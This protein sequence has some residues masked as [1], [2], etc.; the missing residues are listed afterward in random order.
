MH[1]PTRRIRF[2]P[3]DLDLTS[4]ELRKGPTR[5]KVPHQSIEILKALLERPGELVTREELRQ[6][7]WPADT[8]VDFEHG[9]NAATRRLREAL[10]DS[11][12]SPKFV[13][14]LPRRGYRFIG[15]SEQ[16]GTPEPG[17]DVRTVAPAPPQAVEPEPV[18]KRIGRRTR[19]WL[20]P[21][22]ALGAVVIAA[23]LSAAL[24]IRFRQPAE[25]SQP[26]VTRLTAYQGTEWAPTL[27]PDGSMV[28]FSWTG[29]TLS[30]HDI[31]VKV[32]G[33]GE[34]IPLT[35]HPA[36]DDSPAWSPDGQRIAFLRWTAQTDRNVDVM[37]M[38]AL[39]RAAEQLIASVPIRP[40]ASPLKRLAWSPD[41]HWLAIAGEVLP[42]EPHGIWLL[43]IDGRQPRRLTTSPASDLGDVSPAFS[44]D[45]RHLAFIR[46]GSTGTSAIHVL[47]LS[48]ELEP[49][50]DPVQVTD[51]SPQILGVA[52]SPQDRAILFSAGSSFGQ[53][54]L[55]RIR[56]TPDRSRAASPVEVL[57]FGEQATTLS[58]SHA[59]RL[60]YAAQFRDSGLWRANI[61]SG[62]PL[63]ASRELPGSTYD[64]HTPSYSPDG[65]RI[66]FVSTR[67]GTEELWI[68]NVDGTDPRQVTFIGGAQCANPQWSPLG[69]DVILFNSRQH[70]P[71][72]LYL[73]HL[74]T[75]TQ[76]RL[77][78]DAFEDIEARWSR[79]GKWIYF[80]ST[81]TGRLEIWKMPAGGGE[82][83]QVTRNGGATAV[84]GRDGFLYFAKSPRSPTALWRMPI[85]GGD[86]TLVLDGLSYSINFAVG[87]RGIYF[88]SR[89]GENTETAAEYF[90]VA[91]NTRTRL[92]MIGKRWWF[93][94]ALSPDEQ[95]FMYSVVNDMNSNLMLV[96]N[97]Y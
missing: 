34:P 92:A 73:L 48:A 13:E 93:G 46:T 65:H 23:A 97:A 18:S 85:A 89:N 32:V 9:V 1:T 77:T 37:L 7:L 51:A 67:T 57:P 2:G 82:A 35:T 88:I 69:D 62:Q 94:V 40:T 24:L 58:V 27:S 87:R 79:D 50:G 83:T 6:R 36:R 33:P 19:Q 78:I 63:I 31:Y 43:S 74:K 95:W 29:P 68:A 44:F 21:A 11:A 26:R 42:A 66:A 12:D 61:T 64:E 72:E 49:V 3:F 45:G 76:Q 55:H 22:I 30:T 59:G 16:I 81:R 53:T 10:G 86:E 28:A 54:R 70:G 14:T 39:G 15:Q 71:N 25:S 75:G 80:G 91:S 52:W 56:L 4:G 41:G 96:D 84:E 47:G 17:S 60:V 38:P 20:W 90:D 5:L 8:F